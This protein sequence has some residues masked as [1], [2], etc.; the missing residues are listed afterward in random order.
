MMLFVFPLWY[1]VIAPQTPRAQGWALAALLVTFGIIAT[2]APFPYPLIGY[3]AAP[4]LG[5][6]LALGVTGHCD[7]PRHGTDAP[8]LAA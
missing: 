2:I 8:F 6:G 7:Q 3:G 1:R 5:F 4:I